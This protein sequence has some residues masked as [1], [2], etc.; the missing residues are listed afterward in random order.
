MC[1]ILLPSSL[2]SELDS[3]FPAQRDSQRNEA[4]DEARQMPCMLPVLIRLKVS[5]V[6]FDHGV[7][8][9]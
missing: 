4:F 8:T 1:F 9:D 3:S 5:H 7:M 6:A 2:T